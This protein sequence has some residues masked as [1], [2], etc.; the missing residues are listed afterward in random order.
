LK[1]TFKLDVSLFGLAALKLCKYFQPTR[2][3]EEPK[4]ITQYDLVRAEVE[5]IPKLKNYFFGS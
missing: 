3:S 1:I 5:L 2:N 4:T